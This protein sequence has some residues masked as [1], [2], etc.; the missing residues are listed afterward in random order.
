MVPQA[1]GLVLLEKEN[2]NFLIN[3]SHGSYEEHAKMV[4]L[5]RSVS[6]ELD[7]PITLLQD[8]QGPKVRVGYLPQGEI[9]LKEGTFITLIPLDQLPTFGRGSLYGRKNSNG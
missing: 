1:F 4:T 8:L 3:F 9:L 6:L 5:L 2:I 7:N